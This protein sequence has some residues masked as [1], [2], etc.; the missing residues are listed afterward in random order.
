MALGLRGDVF[1]FCLETKWP[2]QL[3]MASIWTRAAGV[4]LDIIVG[5]VWLREWG[6]TWWCAATTAED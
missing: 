6:P 1:V 4:V 5:G 2:V 3:D